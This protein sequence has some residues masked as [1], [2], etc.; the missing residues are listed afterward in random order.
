M[1]RKSEKDDKVSEL[2][3]TA[4]RL[5]SSLHKRKPEDECSNFAN[6]LADALRVMDSETKNFTMFKMRELLYMIQI[7]SIRPPT[8]NQPLSTSTP[9]QQAYYNV[10][11]EMDY[12]YL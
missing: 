6:G 10:S 7:G 12:T 1:K 2:L 9:T 3:S 8:Q 5:L 4:E 11:N